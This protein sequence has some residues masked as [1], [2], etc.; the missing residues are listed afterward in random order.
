VSDRAALRGVVPGTY[1]QLLYDY[2]GTFGHDAQQLLGAAPARDPHGLG[3][4]PVTQW[5]QMLEDSAQ[6]LNDPMLGLHLGQT[7]TPAHFGVMGYVLLSCGDLE[8]VL[9]RILRYQRLLYDVN[10][11]TIQI[12]GDHVDLLWGV[13]H[14]FPGPMVDETAITALLQFC[15]DITAMPELAPTGVD[16]VNAAPK[17]T[18]DYEAYFQCPVRFAQTQTRIRIDAQLLRQPLRA[19]DPTLVAVLEQ[20]AEL[21]LAQLPP[22]E[23]FVAGVRQAMAH[24]LKDGEPTLQSIAE[25]LHV[26]TRTLHRRLDSEGWNFRGLLNDIRG[27]MA[28]DYLRDLRLQISEIAMLLGYSEQSAFTRAFSRWAS[29]SPRAFRLASQQQ[30]ADKSP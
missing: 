6:T 1:V 19:A 17:S 23:N 18:R 27:N 16:F 4:Y 8:G 21:M 11:L 22:A 14:G 10:A 2:L 20:Q 5:K 25:H 29:Q 12:D 9:E 30:E 26:S 3:R 15:R 7:I 28:K 24:A 13:E